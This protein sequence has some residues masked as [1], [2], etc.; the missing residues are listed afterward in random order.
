[1]FSIAG[2]QRK[3][4]SHYNAGARPPLLEAGPLSYVPVMYVAMRGGSCGI[5]ARCPNAG[6]L[7]H[8][9]APGVPVIYQ[10]VLWALTLPASAALP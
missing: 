3:L 7:S 5:A 9:V 1:M 6:L 4:D 8:A 10:V 2:F